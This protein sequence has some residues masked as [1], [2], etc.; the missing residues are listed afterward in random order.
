[1]RKAGIFLFL[2]FLGATAVCFSQASAP[3]DFFAGK[4]EITVLNSPKGDVVFLTDLVRKDGIL[5]GDLVEKGDAANN[6]R[7]I[8]KAEE[9]ADKLVLVFESSQGGEMTLELA[10]VDNDNLKGTLYTFEATA[11]RL[12]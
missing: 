3:A 1:M 11:K 4:W 10:K 5:T 8:L 12:K 7:K 2:L 6:T 9:S